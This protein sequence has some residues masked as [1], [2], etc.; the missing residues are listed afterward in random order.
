MR[1]LKRAPETF[2]RMPEECLHWIR[3]TGEEL[4]KASAR[5]AYEEENKKT[6]LA[7][8]KTTAKAKTEAGRETEARA[9]DE[10]QAYLGEYEEVFF[11]ER[12]YHHQMTWLRDKLEAW[13]T[14]CANGRREWEAYKTGG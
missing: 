3:I 6:V 8:L 5:K 9:S 11:T 2:Q 13:R 7:A 4:A 10:Y 1:E 14:K 12:F